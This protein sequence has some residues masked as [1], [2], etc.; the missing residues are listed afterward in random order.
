MTRAKIMHR[1]TMLV[2]PLLL[3][4]VVALHLN[5]RP[6]ELVASEIRAD[7]ND[8]RWLECELRNDRIT[9][10]RYWAVSDDFP[11]YELLHDGRMDWQ[12]WCTSTNDHW[13]APFSSV[14]MRIPVPEN[15]GHDCRISAMC[16]G[17]SLLSW[18]LWISP[19]YERASAWLMDGKPVPQK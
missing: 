12:M 2:L 1:L 16:E 15:A 10:I 9:P 4:E 5:R 3:F 7:E 17:T 8:S 18:L 6:L 19:E 13:V 11:A 14:K